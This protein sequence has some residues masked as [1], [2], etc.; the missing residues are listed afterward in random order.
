MPLSGCSVPQ[1]PLT[2]AGAT[3]PAGKAVTACAKGLDPADEALVECIRQLCA[4]DPEIVARAA[5]DLTLYARN[6]KKVE[7]QRYENGKWVTKKTVT[8]GGTARGTKIWI[9]RGEECSKTKEVVYHEVMHTMPRQQTMNSREAEIDAYTRTAQW[10]IDRGMPGQFQMTNPDGTKSV[11]DA[12]IIKHVDGA[13]GYGSG[14]KRVVDREDGGK[15]VRLEDGSRRPAKE[16]D[17]FQY[18]P[19]QD[20]NEQQIPPAKLRCK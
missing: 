17:Y 20:L 8:S 10:E 19:P 7:L 6:P 18:T 3:D 1:D 15:T 11:D 9:N 16:G 13:Y 14:E 2:S 4:T 5:D 12:A